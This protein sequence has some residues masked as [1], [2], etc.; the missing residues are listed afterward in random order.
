[1]SPDAFRKATRP[2]VDGSWNLHK[3]LP[4]DMDFFIL[5]SSSTGIIGYRGQANYASGNTYQDALAR[6]RI[7]HGEKA[8]SLNLGML[9]SS[10][11]VAERPEVQANLEKFGLPPI[12]EDE[13]LYLLEYYCNRDLELLSLSKGHV[14][15]GIETPANLKV[16]NVEEPYWLRKSQFRGLHQMDRENSMAPVATSGPEKGSLLVAAAPSHEEAAS[17]ASTCFMEKMSRILCVPIENIDASRPP[18]RFGVDSLVAVEL[19]NWFMSEFGIDMK[20]FEI[21][22]NRTVAEFGLEI[23]QRVRGGE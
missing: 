5:L 19:R 21:L 11:Y 12:T 6:H 4:R 15:T 16:K 1:M 14:I 7:S 3:L 23:A 10:G 13:L 9:A 2:K 8:V 18:H 20:V 22:G 17:I